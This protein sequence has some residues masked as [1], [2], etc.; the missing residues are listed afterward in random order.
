MR[1]G[2]EM[3]PATDGA[4]DAV[5]FVVNGREQVVEGPADESLIETLRE[6]LGLR[7]VRETCG[8]GICGTC[9]VQVDGRSAS[10]CLLLTRQLSGRT[11]RTSE[12][13]VADD[14]SLSRIQQAFLDR[15]AYQCSYCIPGMVVSVDACLRENP[16]ASFEEVREYLA[17]NLCRCG[18]YVSILEAVHDL[19]AT[20]REATQDEPS[21]P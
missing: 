12:G 4:G 1:A 18:T 7:S 3:N 6:S 17:G 16:Q 11:V 8:I 2:N 9:T 13:L 14:G 21:S 20:G 19:V 5:R 15:R 10:A